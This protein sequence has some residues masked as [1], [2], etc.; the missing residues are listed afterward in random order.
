M[1]L[2]IK[3]EDLTHMLTLHLRAYGEQLRNF[4]YVDER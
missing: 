2:L 3:H 4:I 1:D